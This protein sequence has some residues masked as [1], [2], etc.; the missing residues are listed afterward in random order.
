MANK[1]KNGFNATKGR[2]A[3]VFSGKFFAELMNALTVFAFM[4]GL[5]S[6]AA[7]IWINVRPIPTANIKVP[8][9]TDKAQYQPGERISGIFFGDTYFEG[10]VR[11]LREVFCKNYRGVILPPEQSAIGQ[12]FSTQARQRHLE[13]ES[14]VIGNLPDNVPVGANCVLQFTNIYEIQTIFGVRHEE[15]QYYTQN[16]SIVTQDR[17]NQ[18]DCE[19][20]GSEDCDFVTGEPED[21]ADQSQQ[22]PARQSSPETRQRSDPQLQNDTNSTNDTESEPEEPQQPAEPAP[23]FEEQCRV[24]FI[25]KIGCRDVETN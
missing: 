22:A 2:V 17:S 9:A 25:V 4:V 10:E 1:V 24:D 16:F 8:V 3:K 6:L 18:L 11:I 20:T 21:D 19:A 12:L 13:G 23:R 5:L 7:L 14:V 15:Y